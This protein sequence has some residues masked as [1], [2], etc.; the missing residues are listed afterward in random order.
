MN[1]K[2]KYCK[3]CNTTKNISEFHK[4]QQYCKACQKE[5]QKKSQEN[6]RNRTVLTLVEHG[7]IEK[8]YIKAAKLLFDSCTSRINDC[9]KKSGYYHDNNIKFEWD[10]IEEFFIDCF[11]I[12]GFWADWKKQDLIF[13]VTGKKNDRPTIDRINEEGNYSKDNI[14]VLSH[15]ENVL[16]AKRKPCKALVIKN[17]E[18]VGLFEF[19][20]KKQFIDEVKNILP[21]NT[22]RNIKFN[23]GLFHQVKKGTYIILQ[24]KD[25]DIY[26]IA[27]NSN[28]KYRI[29]IDSISNYYYNFASKKIIV[30]VVDIQQDF[31]TNAVVI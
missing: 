23:E 30:E 25:A 22:L 26:E 19:D 15:L 17:H 8:E 31:Y 10:T 14:A 3:D 6:R 13:Q 7:V 2:M 1:R 18:I 9:N 21:V 16:K 4:N 24:T 27:K 12:D 5:Q 20:S 29:H 11:D 28:G